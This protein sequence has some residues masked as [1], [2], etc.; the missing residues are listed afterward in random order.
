[1]ASNVDADSAAH[2]TGPN[3]RMRSSHWHDR[4]LD[5]STG[6]EDAAEVW[7]MS[8]Q[9]RKPPSREDA[10]MMMPAVSAGWHRGRRP[11]PAMNTTEHRVLLGVLTS[12][13][14]TLTIVLIDSSNDTSTAQEPATSAVTAVGA[15]ATAPTLAPP[16]PT[17]TQA[18][19]A[20][21][22][23]LPAELGGFALGEDD[24][25]L[26]IVAGDGPVN[27]RSLPGTT[28]PIVGQIAVGDE[29]MALSTGRV[30][31]AN[32]G[33][34]STESWREV[35]YLGITGWVRTDLVIPTDAN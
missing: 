32:A 5:R 9:Q 28:S 15:G 2:D 4:V 13:A 20:D 27:L 35:E 33:S 21:T 19:S 3:G 30:A 34:D 7:S 6:E 22:A 26:Y 16:Y 12:L 23:P 14:L 31:S 24:R 29:A 25:G 17:A 8:D 18:P 11:M 1:V 10:T